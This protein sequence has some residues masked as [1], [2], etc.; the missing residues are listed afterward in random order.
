V[1]R[2]PQNQLERYG[3]FLN[4]SWLEEEPSIRSF[5]L[6]PS[7]TLSM[8]RMKKFVSQTMQATAAP[9]NLS[10]V[11]K[12]S[13]LPV[14]APQELPVSLLPGERVSAVLPNI[15]HVHVASVSRS[16]RQPA[17]FGCRRRRRLGRALNGSTDALGGDLF[18]RLQ[19][20]VAAGAD[21]YALAGGQSV[22]FDDNR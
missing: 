16:R 15:V 12:A 6:R 20:L 10:A 7:D 21:H 18:D 8:M 2:I 4:E 1:N 11:V 9:G 19:G 17:G 22:G 5:Q 3:V 13:E 14:T